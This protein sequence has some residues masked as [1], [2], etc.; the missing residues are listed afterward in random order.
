MIGKPVKR[1]ASFVDIVLQCIG[2]RD[3]PEPDHRLTLRNGGILS[4]QL[5]HKV[6]R[7]VGHI[8]PRAQH[9]GEPLGC[10]EFQRCIETS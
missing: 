6:S 5:L 4:S 10:G 7:Q 3:R 1:A 2:K 8:D 9:M